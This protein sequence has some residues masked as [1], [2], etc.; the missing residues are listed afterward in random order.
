MRLGV[1]KRCGFCCKYK[2]ALTEFTIRSE[3]EEFAHRYYAK[4]E[5]L[6]YGTKCVIT[7]NNCVITVTPLACRFFKTKHGKATCARHTKSPEICRVYPSSAEHDF[8]RVITR[9]LKV[10]CGYSFT[11]DSY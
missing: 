4:W 3:A 1:C 8:Y 9:D 11:E 2:F 6:V 10:P 5:R 7:P